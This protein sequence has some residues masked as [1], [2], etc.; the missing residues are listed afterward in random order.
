MT[1]SALYRGQFNGAEGSPTINQL[2]FTSP[3]IQGTGGASMQII[4][5][6]ANVFQSLYLMP[7][8]AYRL[9]FSEFSDL[10]VGLGAEIV[11]SRLDMAKV[12][13]QDKDDDIINRYGA[14]PTWNYD[15]TFGLHYKHK[16]FKLGAVAHRLRGILDSEREN[17]LLSEQVSAY[18]MPSIPLNGF[19]DMLEILVFY[20]SLPG[21]E[22]YRL[23]VG[24]YYTFS[25]LATFGASYG[26]NGEINVLAG[27][28]YRG[29]FLNYNHGVGVQS[30]LQNTGFISEIT[31]GYHLFSGGYRSQFSSALEQTRDARRIRRLDIYNSNNV[32]RSSPEKFGRKWR[33]KKQN[34]SNPNSRFNK[35]KK[36]YRKKKKRKKN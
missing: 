7:S 8:M 2:A 9:V 34:S 21:F 28:N 5:D 31:L 19:R 29:F 14:D 35:S 20:R 18:F 32:G 30:N 10:S 12:N 36:N 17:K 23:D 16:Y 27:V 22:D 11:N 25:E 13:V 26:L 3:I 33:S 4:N 24:A 15:F 6:N 1:L